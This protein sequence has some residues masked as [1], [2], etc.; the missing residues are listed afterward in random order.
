MKKALCLI[1]AI[2]LLALLA[3]CDATAPEA[4]YNDYTLPGHT[5]E[6]TTTAIPS[7]EETAERLLAV[8]ALRDEIELRA[9]LSS[10]LTIAEQYLDRIDR[11]VMYLARAQILF[12]MTDDEA[13]VIQQ[14]RSGREPIYINSLEYANLHLDRVEVLL[15]GGR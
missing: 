15:N 13:T 6:F 11:A 12:D 4:S 3:A 9:A 1:A 7:L 2:A 10:D 14:I 5:Q 8:L